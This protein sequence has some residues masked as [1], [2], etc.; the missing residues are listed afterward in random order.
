MNIY[1]DI[2]SALEN[3]EIMMLATIISTFGSTP[4][5]SLSKMLV[6]NKGTK[7]VGT[8]GGGLVES[9]GTNRGK[10]SI[11]AWQSQNSYISS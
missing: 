9:E 5:S 6:M 8:I 11:A 4:A 1:S 3:E 2:I 10:A 7:F